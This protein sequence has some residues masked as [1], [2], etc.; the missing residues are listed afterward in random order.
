ME[1]RDPSFDEFG[2]D[3]SQ[4]A[5]RSDEVENLAQVDTICAPSKVRALS[6]REVRLHEG[7][8]GVVKAQGVQSIACPFRPSEGTATL[9]PPKPLLRTSR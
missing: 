9:D 6:G 5:G 8:N 3:V 7:V 1:L 2:P 4:L